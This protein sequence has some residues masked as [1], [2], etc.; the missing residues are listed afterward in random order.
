[1]TISDNGLARPVSEKDYMNLFFLRIGA[2]I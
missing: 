1:M 2:E